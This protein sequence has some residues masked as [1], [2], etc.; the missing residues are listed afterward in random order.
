MFDQFKL[1]HDVFNMNKE[2]WM[3]TMEMMSNFHEH[4]AEMWNKMMEQGLISQQKGQEMITEWT[5][6]TKQAQQE[7]T[8]TIQE[9][10]KKA[11][12]TFNTSPKSDK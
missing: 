11:E 2:Y 1:T 4:Y 9:N 3:K 8:R 6:K 10:L 12:S 7:F 5:A